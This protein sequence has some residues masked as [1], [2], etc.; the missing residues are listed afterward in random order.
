MAPTAL[1]PPIRPVS[2]AELEQVYGA[3]GLLRVPDAELPAVVTDPGARA[4]LGEVGL[5][6]A[7]GSMVR[8]FGPPL[9]ALAVDC[10][11]EGPA[12]YW[13]GLPGDGAGMVVVGNYG[14]G[15][16]ALDGA[17][18]EVYALGANRPPTVDGRPAHR[19]L[20]S[21]ARCQLAFGGLELSVMVDQMDPDTIDW[22]RT[23]LPEFAELYPPF[24]DDDEDVDPEFF[25]GQPALEDIVAGLTAK[26]LAVEP[27]LLDQPVWQDIMHDFQHGY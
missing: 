20:H 22:C 14:S 3:D 6:D 1:Q 4:F 17:T 18:G 23:H 7:P 12:H 9:R 27:G 26:L 13:P 16:F 2:R 8:L 24:L 10:A 15:I 25:A 11:P 5:I 19:S 21:L